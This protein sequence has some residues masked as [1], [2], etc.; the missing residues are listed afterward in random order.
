[1]KLQYALCRLA[2]RRN[3]SVHFPVPD[4]VDCESR[5]NIKRIATTDLFQSYICKG[6]PQESRATDIPTTLIVVNSIAYPI[7]VLRLVS[8]WLVAGKLWWDDWII[9]A[10]AVSAILTEAYVLKLIPNRYP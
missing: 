3:N 10:A 7:L 1:M 4:R 6:I 8:R 5:A 2:V 9:V